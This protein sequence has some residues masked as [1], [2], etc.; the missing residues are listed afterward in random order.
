MLP[1]ENAQTIAQL[2]ARAA[3]DYGDSPAIEDGGQRISYRQLE[4]LRQQA[5]RAL[6]ALDVQVADRVAV[7][8]P[9]LWEWIVAAGAL[10]S[11]GATLVPLNTRMKGSEAGHILRESGT[12]VLFCISRFLDNDYP[13]MLA[14][15]TLPALRQVISLR[16][17]EPRHGGLAWEA[18]MALAEQVPQALL[19]ARE[20]QVGPQTLSDLL[21]TSGTSGK[22]KGVMTAHGQNL[23]VVRDWS[24]IVGLRR[25]IAT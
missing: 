3:R 1:V 4:L 13:A 16:P 12:C 8:A 2:F 17:A 19:Q 5:A 24:E 21:F 15:Q 6:L 10:Q 18:F 11:I 25:A 7:W 22:P 9:N 20:Q 23:Q 14:D